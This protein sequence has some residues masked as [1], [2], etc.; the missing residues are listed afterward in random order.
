MKQSLLFFFIL[1]LNFSCLS[2]IEKE[3]FLFD[4]SKKVSYKANAAFQYGGESKITILPKFSLVR[5]HQAKIIKPYYGAAIGLHPN[6]ISAAFTFAG[7]GG[8]EVKQF[9]IESSISHFRTTRISDG[10]DGFKGPYAQNAFNLKIGYTI[11]RFTL[12]LGRSFLISEHFPE[13]DERIGILDIGKINGQ[14]FG[15]ELQWRIN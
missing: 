8:I 14:T 13:G 4:E 3:P 2:Q 6:L 7:I 15:I 11:K 12:K 10:L 1:C 5:I 9:S